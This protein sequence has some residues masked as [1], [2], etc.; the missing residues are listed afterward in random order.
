MVGGATVV[1][2]DA[3]L[4][5]LK[6]ITTYI[7][8]HKIILSGLDVSITAP[9]STHQPNLYI[10]FQI[11]LPFQSFAMPPHVFRQRSVVI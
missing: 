9:I 8:A 2:K 3:A 6:D 5:I 4:F 7:D 11:Y 1:F 10:P